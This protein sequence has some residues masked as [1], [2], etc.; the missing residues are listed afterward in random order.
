MVT[1]P[2]QLWS[3]LNLEWCL[4]FELTVQSHCSTSLLVYVLNYKPFHIPLKYRWCPI[5]KRDHI[6]STYLS[7]KKFNKISEIQLMSPVKFQLLVSLVC[8]WQFS[9]PHL[10]LALPHYFQWS[11]KPHLA[12]CFWKCVQLNALS[13]WTLWKPWQNLQ[14]GITRTYLPINKSDLYHQELGTAVLSFYCEP[15]ERSFLMR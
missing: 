3:M 10:Y 9:H 14:N 13:I 12:L 1:W 2:S 7:S 6:M 5:K 11:I 8:L 15:C 4:Y